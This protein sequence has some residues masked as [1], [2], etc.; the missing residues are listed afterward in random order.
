MSVSPFNTGKPT[1][2]FK[3]IS[4]QS[5]T[6][7]TPITAWDPAAGKKFVLLGWQLSTSAAA[8]FIFKYGSGPSTL[9]RT[10]KYAAAAVSTDPPGYSDL[11]YA[12]NA[13]DDNLLLDVSA[14]STVEG[15]V[16]GYEI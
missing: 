16:W 13:A 14:T 11:A 9:L 15:Y 2:V 1:T 6:A 8:A 12:P 10:A 5:I 3:A 7:G 4:S